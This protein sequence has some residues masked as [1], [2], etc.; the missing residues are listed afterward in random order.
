M[1]EAILSNT[2][3]GRIVDEFPLNDCV[4]VRVLRAGQRFQIHALNIAKTKR[5]RVRAFWKKGRN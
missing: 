3:P 5:P 4:G 2:D 1:G